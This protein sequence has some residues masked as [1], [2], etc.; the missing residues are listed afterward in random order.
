[1]SN[2]RVSGTNVFDRRAYTGSTEM[3]KATARDKGSDLFIHSCALQKLC[4]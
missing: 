2:P 3:D 1:M 4:D